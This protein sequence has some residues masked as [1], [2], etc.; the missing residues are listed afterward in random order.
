MNAVIEKSVEL[1]EASARLLKQL[2]MA[3]GA[4][5]N[6]LIEEAL[7]LLFR[8]HERRTA[9]EA[10]I[11]E[12]SEELARLEAYL[13][14]VPEPIGAPFHIDPDEIVSIVGTPIAPNRIVHLEAEC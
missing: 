5:E 6:A 8:E 2:A 13:E 10:A 12:D 14:P 4:S 11:R 1:S 3:R 9:R 7:A